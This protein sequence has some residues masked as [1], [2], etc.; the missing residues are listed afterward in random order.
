MNP[1]KVWQL[2]QDKI[3]KIVI[4]NGDNEEDFSIFSDEEIDLVDS[5]NTIVSRSMIHADDSIFQ[6]KLKIIEKLN[7]KYGDIYMFCYKTRKAPAMP[8]LDKPSLAQFMK[9]LDLDGINVNT[10]DNIGFD[11]NCELSLKTPL[12]M[13]CDD[14]LFSPNPFHDDLKKETKCRL[15]EHELLGNDIDCNNIYVCLAKDALAYSSSSSMYFPYLNKEDVKAN[16]DSLT[17]DEL[18]RRHY[19]RDHESSAKCGITSVYIEINAIPSSPNLFK[20]IHATAQFPFI[21]HTAEFHRENLYRLYSVT[22]TKN[23]KRIPLLSKDKIMKLSKIEKQLVIYNLVYNL[24]ITFDDSGIVTIE[25]TFDEGQSVVDIETMIKIAVNPLLTKY[26]NYTFTSL[27]DANQIRMCYEHWIPHQLNLRNKYLHAVFGEKDFHFKRV[28]NYEAM[29]TFNTFLSDLYRKHGTDGTIQELV[30]KHKFD[31]SN[32]TSKVN[33]F[34]ANG[35]NAGLKT[36]IDEYGKITVYDLEKVDYIKSLTMYIDSI[37]MDIVSP[38]ITMMKPQKEK[39]TEDFEIDDELFLEDDDD[40]CIGFS[41]DEDEDDEEED[42]DSDAEDTL[43]SLYYKTHFFKIFKTVVSKLLENS[44]NQEKIF[45]I[46]ENKD[47][48]RNKKIEKII[49]L[50]QKVSKKAVVYSKISKHV[51]ESMDLTSQA[52]LQKDNQ[53]IIPVEYSEFYPEKLAQEIIVKRRQKNKEVV[54]IDVDVDE[55]LILESLLKSKD[56]FEDMVPSETSLQIIPYEKNRFWHMFS[57]VNVLEFKSSF[58]PMIYILHQFNNVLYSIRTVKKML[59][60]AY[61]Q[62]FEINKKKMIQMMQ[63][64]HSIGDKF[65]NDELEELIKSESY[66]MTTIDLWVIAQAYRIPIVLFSSNGMLQNTSS[67]WLVLGYKKG[68]QDDFFFVEAPSMRLIDRTFN[69]EEMDPAFREEFTEKF[70]TNTLSLDQQ[71][72]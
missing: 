44:E 25:G 28:D 24:V 16:P 50:I 57:K 8:T 17:I 5:D 42:S 14:V 61:L 53:L 67:R 52:L 15:T 7:C 60:T 47:F 63:R 65:Y 43:N 69:L 29:D 72:R 62:Y 71:I 26:C 34:I 54:E 66:S 1:Y 51:L 18:Y 38:N 41:E 36:T 59:W 33:A 10:C 4:F 13:E 68:V 58:T 35:K 56:Y 37:V 23:G 3:E 27:K 32:A 39:E 40:D 12:G 2:N 21:K 46:V 6:I 30:N 22:S 55:S 9:N 19:N 64:E 45:K 49:K 70:E 20:K 31:K 48:S 11:T